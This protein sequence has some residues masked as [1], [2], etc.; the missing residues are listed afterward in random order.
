IKNLGS[1]LKEIMAASLFNKPKAIKTSSYFIIRKY[2]VKEIV[3]YS[4]PYPYLA[5]LIL[6]ATN[7]IGVVDVTHK[8]RMYGKSNYSFLKMVELWINGFTNFSVKPLQ[9]YF[10]QCSMYLFL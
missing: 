7:N 3:N 6:R 10:H 2:L 1:R 4:G 8:G 9:F 5:G